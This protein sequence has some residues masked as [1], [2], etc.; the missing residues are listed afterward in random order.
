MDTGAEVSVIPPSQTDCKSSQQNLNLQAVN[1]TS[2]TT[3]GSRS[4]TLNL[5]LH[6]K[7]C[8]IFIITD[9]QHPILGADFLY[10]YS[11]LVDMS[12]NRLLDS[13]T[14][15]K[16]QG[17]VTLVSSPSPTLLTASSTNEFAAILPKLS[18]YHYQTRDKIAD[19]DLVTKSL[20]CL[21]Y[22]NS[23]P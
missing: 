21:W 11:L 8:W 14:Q 7:F 5:G 10:I 18:W 17:I 6:L 19:H 20:S 23:F 12:H 9:I 15:L 22:H 2:I 4:L 3:Y 13:L 1:I 16:V